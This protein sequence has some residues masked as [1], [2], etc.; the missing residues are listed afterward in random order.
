[1]A[2]LHRS[3]TH[4]RCHMR[5]SPP[6]SFSPPPLPCLHTL[7]FSYFKMKQLKRE[8]MSEYA[9]GHAHSLSAMSV[10]APLFCSFSSVSDPI[11]S[12]STFT[13]HLSFSCALAFPFSLQNHLHR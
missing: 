1:M 3:Q 12:V 11:L 5:L 4:P 2:T 10:H 6:P 13:Y 9:S 7:H 8:V